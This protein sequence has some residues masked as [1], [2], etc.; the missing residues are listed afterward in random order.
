MILRPHEKPAYHDFLFSKKRE[1]IIE[2]DVYI[3]IID[4]AVRQNIGDDPE[5]HINILDFGC[6]AGYVSLLLAEQFVDVQNLHIY[7]LDYQEDLLDQFWKRIVQNELKNVTPFH[8]NEQNRI[9]YPKWLPSMDIALFS[10]SLSASSGPDDI[11]ETTGR[12]MQP[13]GRI[14][15]FD[16][17]ADFSEDTLNEVFPQEDRLTPMILEQIIERSGYQLQN[18]TGQYNI[19]ASK[20]YFFLEGFRP[21][22]NHS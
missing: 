10:F 17:S 11:L 13:S 14:F 12:V 20:G 19:T 8:L 18:N 5:K 1:Q 3:K 7:A 6:G 22:R 2:P 4:S 21:N 16:W 9:F 15:I